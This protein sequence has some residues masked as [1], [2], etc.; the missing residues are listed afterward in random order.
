MVNWQKPLETD[1]YL[2]ILD[3][4]RERDEHIAKL[5]YTGDTN[6]PANQVKYD[7]SANKFQRFDGTSTWTNLGF[8]TAIDSHI[9]DTS[10]HE[11]F[12]TGDVKMGAYSA[13]PS[14]WLLCNGQAVSRA[15]FSA[16]FTKIGTSYGIGDGSTTFNVPDFTTRSPIG[17]G[18]TVALG[19]ATG[20]WNHSHTVNAHSHG[21]PSHTHGMKNHTHVV[22]AHKH[23]VSPH[24]HTIRAHGH[25]TTNANATIN[26]T[27]SGSHDH[28]GTGRS[29]DNGTSPLDKFKLTGTGGTSA[30]Y[31]VATTSSTH[32]HTNAE[33]A[34]TVGNWNG[35]GGGLS[36]DVNQQTSSG[37]LSETD[38]NTGTHTTNAPN[39]NITDANTAA[40]TT[41]TDSSPGTNGANGP[42]LG[43][44]FFIKT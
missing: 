18:A 9:A 43:I 16:L 36:G 28:T 34:G 42:V 40:L 33:F 10:L 24:E 29:S 35:G 23:P 37:T 6:V 14:G 20:A 3:W 1:S 4:I 25:S 5:D 39:D 19:A 26:I 15:G 17:A 2:D 31:T 32:T 44:N 21:I 11:S 12:K 38:N 22:P 41:N 30:T 8:H 13:V 7:T 27:A